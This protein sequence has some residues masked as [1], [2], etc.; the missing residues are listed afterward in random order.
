LY[1]PVPVWGQDVQPAQPTQQQSPPVQQQYY[2]YYPQVEQNPYAQRPWGAASEG[3]N[4]KQKGGQTVQT[5]QPSPSLPA[6]QA[7][8]YGGYQY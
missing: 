3:G 2:Y 5:W 6:W 8:A 4:S 7:P 1:A